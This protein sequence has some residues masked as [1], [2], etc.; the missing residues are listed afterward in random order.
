MRS[1][2]GSFSGFSPSLRCLVLIR[3]NSFSAASSVA[4]K[5]LFRFPLTR[6]PSMTYF[7]VAEKVKMR[8]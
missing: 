7:A 6:T 8:P 1:A 5:S 4:K 2:S 3:A